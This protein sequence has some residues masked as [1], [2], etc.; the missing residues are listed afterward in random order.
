[1]AQ[2]MPIMMM[3]M[4]GMCLSS[5]VG[6]ALMMGGEEKPAPTTTAAAGT[7]TGTGTGTGADADAGSTTTGAELPSEAPAVD[8]ETLYTPPPPPPPVAGQV[9]GFKSVKLCSPWRERD[10]KRAGAVMTCDEFR[11]CYK[12]NKQAPCANEAWYNKCGY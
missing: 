3:G 9:S 11:A 6:A 1:M 12:E 4:M 10:C 5:S 7:G 8:A 2:M